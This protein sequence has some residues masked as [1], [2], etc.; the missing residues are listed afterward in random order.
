M[1][2]MY[3]SCLNIDG[4]ESF[5]AAEALERDDLQR[6]LFDSVLLVLKLA[7]YVAERSGFAASLLPDLLRTPSLP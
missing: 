6:W 4:I 7:V 5:L 3:E 1:K 2:F